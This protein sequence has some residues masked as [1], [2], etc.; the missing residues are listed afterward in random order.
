[1]A[2]GYHTGRVMLIAVLGFCWMGS[3]VGIVCGAP[4]SPRTRSFDDG[5]RFFRGDAPGA[6]Q[7]GF[8]D[9][10]WRDVDTPHDWSI[11][12]LPPLATP[13]R[14]NLRL[15]LS[16]G[17]WRFKAG[18]DPSWKAVDL[19]EADWREVQTPANWEDHGQSRDSNVYGWFRRRIN[20]P[21][22]MKGKDIVIDLGCID[23]CDESFVNG[24]RVG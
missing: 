22:E 18:D 20:V 4:A 15:D 16:R 1:M 5:W 6:E 3:V 11:E 21:A 7:P 19:D 2:F 14:S 17:T 10:A 12:D 13:E 23:D 9:A 24:E 8:N